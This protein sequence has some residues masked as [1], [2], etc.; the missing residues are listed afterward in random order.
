MTVLGMTCLA[1]LFAAAFGCNSTPSP[2]EGQSRP[3]DVLP[4]SSPIS[5]EQEFVPEPRTFRIVPERS[6][7]R[8]EV[9]EELTF[10]GIPLHLA[11][12]RTS[13]M[14]GELSFYRDST[15][16][17]KLVVTSG[18][19]QVDLSTLVSD[20]VRRDERIREQWLE[21]DRYPLAIFEAKEV[22]G[23]PDD[24]PPDA[25]HTATWSFD[26]KGEMTVRDVT[27]EE[28]FKIRVNIIEESMEGTA[29]ATLKMK[30]YGFNPP[31]IAGLFK[32]END[33]GVV[34]EFQAEEILPAR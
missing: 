30:N 12:G 17:E 1:V 15:D 19:F 28:T 25:G 21:S 9:S 2:D 8:Y 32:V 3:D 23:F 31:E 16:G 11:T 29:N 34:L 22:R 7:A 33:V 24:L 14:S 20:D 13:E 4:V 6:E 18:R 26:L 10:L 27:R 5:G